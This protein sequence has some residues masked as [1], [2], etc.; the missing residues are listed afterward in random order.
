MKRLSDI[1]FEKV[2]YWQAVEDQI[3]PKL[4]R[5]ENAQRVLYAF[6]CDGN[7]KYIGKTARSLSQRLSGYKSPGPSQSTNIKNN[8]NIRDL[9][10]LDR[11]VEIWAFAD[12]K[13]L[14]VGEF[15]VNLAAGLEDDLI[16]K[17]QPPWNGRNQTS[18]EVLPDNV[19]AT[20]MHTEAKRP[21]ERSAVTTQEA[22]Y[23]VTDTQFEFKL[24]KT[25]FDQGFFNVGVIAADY[26]AGDKAQI[27]IRLGKNGD[28]IIGHINRTANANYTPRIMG[29]AKLRDWFQRNIKIGNPVAVKILSDTSIWIHAPD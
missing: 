26:F 16:A 29:G 2:G 14:R 8:A 19:E 23:G 20:R 22:D 18:K 1:G 9:L 4:T 25:Y 13:D 15:R 27:E 6:V 11:L 17:I 28:I 5:L 12:N 21:P 7:V 10:S 3:E 24:G